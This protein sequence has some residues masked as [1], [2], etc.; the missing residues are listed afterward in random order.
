MNSRCRLPRTTFSPAP[1]L[2]FS[3][4]QKTSYLFVTVFRSVIMSFS[5]H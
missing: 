3:C 1:L 5:D 2:R 4:A